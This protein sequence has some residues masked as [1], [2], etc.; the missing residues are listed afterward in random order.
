MIDSLIHQKRSRH[1]YSS[2]ENNTLPA[3]LTANQWG[4]LE[5]T[6]KVLTPFEELTTNVSAASATAA[7]VIPSVH[8][9]IRFL[10]KESEDDQAIQTMKATLMDVVD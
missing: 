6:S 7:D 8:V 1:A 2:E 5:K 9:L 4:L 10:S 3:I